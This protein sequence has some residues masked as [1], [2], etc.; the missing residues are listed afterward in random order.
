LSLTYLQGQYV[1]TF[2]LHQ[3]QL[4]LSEDEDADEIIIELFIA[5]TD[6]FIMELLSY[7]SDAEVKE[8]TS[9]RK[10]MK[11]QLMNTLRYYTT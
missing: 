8:P 9:L 11:Q 1:K 5:V 4:I 2:P 6:D 10:K 3:S 7:G